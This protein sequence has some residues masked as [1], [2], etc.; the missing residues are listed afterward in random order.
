MPRQEAAMQASLISV[1][2]SLSQSLEALPHQGELQAKPQGQCSPIPNSTLFSYSHPGVNP[3]SSQPARDHAR[4]S[5]CH[6]LQETTLLSDPDRVWGIQQW[7][8]A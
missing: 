5:A 3:R 7:L 4:L 8:W 2:A 6:N 1:L